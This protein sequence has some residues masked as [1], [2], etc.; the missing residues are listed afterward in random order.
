MHT[1]TKTGY[2]SSSTVRLAIFIPNIIFETEQKRSSQLLQTFNYSRTL[3]ISLSRD[4]RIKDSLRGKTYQE[5]SL[6]KAIG[7]RDFKNQ[8]SYRGKLLMRGLLIRVLLY[9]SNI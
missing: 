1:H 3:L 9:L 6:L 8:T 4:Q 5:G 7:F 2:Y